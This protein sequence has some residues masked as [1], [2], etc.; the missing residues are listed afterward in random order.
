M[1][2]TSHNTIKF[3][4]GL[5]CG[6]AGKT[7]DVSRHA[8]F[9]VCRQEPRGTSESDANTHKASFSSSYLAHWAVQ[10]NR[11]DCDQAAQRSIGDQSHHRS[12]AT[13]LG[14]VSKCERTPA[15]WRL[16][17]DVLARLSRHNQ[18]PLLR[19]PERAGCL[20][21]GHVSRAWVKR[22]AAVVQLRCLNARIPAQAAL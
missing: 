14:I 1:N 6:V 18:R 17:L 22:L 20:L 13:L 2:C 15:T 5:S 9:S 7:S 19:V 3:F 11:D 21:Q 4:G 12:S 8:C 16:K 10:R